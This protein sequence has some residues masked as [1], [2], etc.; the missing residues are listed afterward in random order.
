MRAPATVV[1]AVVAACAPPPAA[2]PASTP[3][4]NVTPAWQVR[5][6]GGQIGIE[7]GTTD[8]ALLE[9]GACAT[10]HDAIVDEWRT[11]RHAMAW[12][13][14]I[15]QREYQHRPQD[16]CVNCHAP[17]PAQQAGLAAGDTALADQ[18]IDCATCH[19]RAGAIVSA[20][21]SPRSPHAT[22]AEPSFGTPA[23]CADCHEF[24]F[25]VLDRRGAA[26]RMTAHPMQDTIA[27][28]RAGPFAG[29]RDG[30]MT[31]HG[32]A[33]NHAFRG[34][35]DA[36]MR[37][38]AI[39]VAWCRRGDALAVSVTNAG[40]GHSVPTGDIHRH[41][42]LRIWRA[43]APEAMFE[44]F[45]GRRFEPDDDGGGKR[46]IWDSRLPPGGGK[47]HVV[48][49]AA[50]AGTD[51]LDDSGR[52][53]INLEL[54]YVFIEDEF[55]RPWRA[56]SEPSAVGVVRWQSAVADLPACK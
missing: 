22:I 7:T 35:H 23:F 11:S 38:G 45:Y 17:T 18:G 36:A 37:D 55:P 28:F 44:A 49:I 3:P 19:V 48:D 5:P 16:W 33:Q 24:T 1:A 8:R 2:P 56:P 32:S 34:G 6:S 15:F 50:L 10:C 39:E 9:V 12:T 14:G 4:S 21:R 27:S 20:R 25:P 52:E 51:P 46:T 43:S 53:P 40:A 30:C 29:E 13:N 54:N 47:H 42:N 41:M 26:T 31:C